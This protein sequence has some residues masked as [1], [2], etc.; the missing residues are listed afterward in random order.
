[1]AQE[2]SSGGPIPETMIQKSSSDVSNDDDF[3]RRQD[4][5]NIFKRVSDRE[6]DFQ[7]KRNIN[8]N[9]LQM[10]KADVVKKVFSTM[11]DLGVDL[12]DME[13]I[14]KFLQQLGQQDPDL[15]ILFESAMGGLLPAE[16]EEGVS[17]EGVA[18]EGVP[19]KG[20]APDVGSSMDEKAGP[21]LM[22]KNFNL[23]EGILR[24]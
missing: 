12:D 16:K 2:N 22:D 23:Q 3:A 19:V 10:F 13:S 24:E 4:V 14:N 15:L 6:S 5:E 21:S 1:M 18:P 7:E 8:E 20:I 17:V 11:K 9:K